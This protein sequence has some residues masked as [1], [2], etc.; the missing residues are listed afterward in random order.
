M[1]ARSIQ[2]IRSR[3]AFE[4]HCDP[5]AFKFTP[6]VTEPPDYGGYVSAAK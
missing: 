4:T 6:L 5:G 1:N 3:A 2:D